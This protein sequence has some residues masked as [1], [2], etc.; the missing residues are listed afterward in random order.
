M[1]RGGQSGYGK[2]AEAQ[3][4]VRGGFTLAELLIAGTLVLLLMTGLAAVIDPSHATSRAQAAATDVRLRLRA[5]SEALSADLHGAGS[6]PVNGVFG[7]SLGTVTPAVL[8]LRIGSRGDPAGTTRADAFSVIS[9]A[10]VGA[11]AELA[12]LF[13]PGTAVARI[14]AVS[15]CQVSDPSCG[16]RAGAS[17]LILDGR[18]Q[19]DLFN[20]TAVNG[21]WLTLAPRGATSGRP[22]P[23]GSLLVPVTVACYYLR[24]GTA[25]DGLQL[26]AGDGD[27]WEL[28][29]V[30]HLTGLSIELLGDPRP[31]RLG[32]L[33]NP[34]RAATYGPLPPPD[35]VDD[36]RD[37]WPAGENCTFLTTGGAQ[38][39]R[40]PAL[41]SAGAAGLV[42]LSAS[43][44]T[45]GPW[46][47]DGSAPNRYDADLLRVRAVRVT[48]RVEAALA[49]DRGPDV[50][51]FLHPGLSRDRSGVAADQVVVL[52]VVPR[53]LQAGR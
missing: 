32:S 17:V 48:I 53:A 23:A 11:A 9:T 35:G 29:L 26:M 15:G 2:S 42:V 6:G 14:S 8:P 25:A 28:P 52:D 40:M 5:A 39:S 1:D 18:G 13:V 47:P 21:Q 38:Q 34:S 49:A 3:L 43:V 45:D 41:S 4:S 22:F 24:T 31:P 36:L 51:L 30:D 20:V 16:V 37:D 44:L 33:G 19:S 27:T 12:D 50:R 7:R 10:G 46:C